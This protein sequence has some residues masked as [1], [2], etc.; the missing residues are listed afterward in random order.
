MPL[1]SPN[2]VEHQRPTYVWVPSQ[3]TM[4]EDLRMIVKRCR[5]YSEANRTM[6]IRQECD[7]DKVANYIRLIELLGRY[8]LYN[9]VLDD[10][11]LDRLSPKAIFLCKNR[12]FLCYWFYEIIGGEI[13][14]GDFRQL[15]KITTILSVIR[16]RGMERVFLEGDSIYVV[17]RGNKYSLTTDR[18][19]WED[20]R[21]PSFSINTKSH[22]VLKFYLVESGIRF[23]GQSP[24][25]DLESE[26]F[27]CTYY[28][29]RYIYDSRAQRLLGGTSL[30]DSSYFF[31]PHGIDSDVISLSE[32]E[33]YIRRYS[34]DDP[35]KGFGTRLFYYD[36]A[37]LINSKLYPSGKST[38]R[39]LTQISNDEIAVHA[40]PSK[41]IR[42]RVDECENDIRVLVRAPRI[43]VV[44][45]ER[46]D[47]LVA[48]HI[49][50]ID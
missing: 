37:G 34:Y 44:N 10:L 9:I 4:I 25:I 38:M 29:D 3:D 13:R 43:L 35:A 33:D 39:V 36:E 23:S 27:T 5:Q 30:R 21:L 17:Y 8:G 41:F 11:S 16:P 31:I 7:R 26:R 42:R 20:T 14:P 48:E 18:R 6:R 47:Q 28:S 50:E 22:G 24:H 15:K 40:S 32:I 12:R 49:I 2:A 45:K 1:Y 46:I 19:G